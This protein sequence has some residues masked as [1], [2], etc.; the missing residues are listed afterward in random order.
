[1]I[2]DAATGTTLPK[3]LSFTTVQKEVTP[4]GYSWAVYAKERGVQQEIRA[5]LQSTLNFMVNIHYHA[6]Y[7]EDL[8]ADADSF[9]IVLKWTSSSVRESWNA[10]VEPDMEWSKVVK[11]ELKDSVAQLEAAKKSQSD[12]DAAWDQTKVDLEK[13]K[14]SWPAWQNGTPEEKKTAQDQEKALNE[15]VAKR[16]KEKAAN[17]SQVA[18]DTE[19]VDYAKALELGGPNDNAGKSQLL[20]RSVTMEAWIVGLWTIHRQKPNDASSKRWNNS[21][22]ASLS[23]EDFEDLKSAFVQHFSGPQG[24]EGGCDFITD[25]LRCQSKVYVEFSMFASDGIARQEAEVHSKINPQYAFDFIDRRISLSS[26]HYLAV[27]GQ[28]ASAGGGSLPPEGYTAEAIVLQYQ[29]A[30]AC[31]IFL[32][33]RHKT[34]KGLKEVKDLKKTLEGVKLERVLEAQEC[35]TGL[36]KAIYELEVEKKEG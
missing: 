28:I 21:K 19:R 33:T 27:T 15:A 13:D 5:E 11:T 23:T 22:A 8:C 25:T 30:L 34:G 17:D 14:A 29:E 16:E 32:E 4:G 12:A 6:P 36:F 9:S 18:V 26:I 2:I 1:M 31:L 24:I 3:S 20:L 7:L 35:L 10:D